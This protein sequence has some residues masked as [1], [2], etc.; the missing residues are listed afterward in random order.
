MTATEYE[1]LGELEEELLETAYESSSESDPLLR[2]LEAGHVPP[3]RCTPLGKRVGN[4]TCSNAEIAA[5]RAFLKL[6]TL[7][8]PALRAAVETVAGRAVSLATRAADALDRSRRTDKTRRI[9]CEAFGV[10]PEFVPPWRASL[11]GVVRWRDLGELVAIRLKDVAKILDGG[12]IHYFCWGS[13][14]HCPE[15]TGSPTT[16]FACSSFLDRYIICL[17]G[18]FWRAWK[19]R[20]T[21]T[22]ASTLLHE[23]LHIYF[24]R[25]VSHKGRSGN[26]NCYER[27]A[28]RLQNLFLH[29]AT[30]SACP[31]GSCSPPASARI[32]EMLPELEDEL[33]LAEEVAELELPS[34]RWPAQAFEGATSPAAKMSPLA[35]KSPRG[36]NTRGGKRKKPVW[37]I[38]IH[39]TGSGPA[40][41][42]T[43]KSSSR[44]NKW[45]CKS[46][47]ECAL[48]FY[49]G[50]EGFPHYVIDYDG[51]I[52]SVSP[53]D[54][55]DWHAGWTAETGGRARWKRWSPPGWWS[56]VW[57]AGK[58]PLDLIPRDANSPNTRHIGI[59]LLG[60]RTDRLYTDAQYKALA[61][62]AVDIERRYGLDF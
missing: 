54:H 50:G 16:Y 17:G 2:E 39:T 40:T 25:T 6:P 35:I 55:V 33:D 46:P 37:G 48:A 45:K 52:Y 10:T 8:A 43:E 30:A 22:T 44:R 18:P 60:D 36:W 4:F 28:V 58:T 47:I 49:A 14:S 59:E 38:V 56:S 11:H 15:C 27:F 42:A 24:G 53:E 9:F 62:L 23:A 13:P 32:R 34:P 1:V 57:G 5:I 20:D 41:I 7:T 29:S 61:R 12:C 21:A 26:A 51:T 19:S 3:G 31:A